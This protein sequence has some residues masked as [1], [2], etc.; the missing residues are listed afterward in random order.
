[1]GPR[2]R[3]FN[4]MI[5]STKSWWASVPWLTRM[6]GR[7]LLSKL[8]IRLQS[9]LLIHPRILK[10][11]TSGVTA[12]ISRRSQM[13]IG[14]RLKIN[15]GRRW[16]FKS[17]IRDR[18][19]RI[20]IWKFRSLT[21]PQDMILQATWKRLSL[22]MKITSIHRLKINLRMTILMKWSRI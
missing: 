20:K 1:M 22:G 7:F 12:K 8:S 13:R 18:W 4:T 11:L 3:P 17:Q 21:R 6:L 14:Q 19:E 10:Y 16:T 5:P 2:I 9:T 15:R